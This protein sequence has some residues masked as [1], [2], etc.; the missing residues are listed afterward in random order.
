MARYHFHLHECGT[1]IPDEEGVEKRDMESVRHEALRA[2]RELMCA[3]MM[4]GKLCLGCQIE[5]QDAAGE[6]VY[7]LPFKEGVAITGV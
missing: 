3:E 2:A 1:F 4:R 6:V 5:V 7:I